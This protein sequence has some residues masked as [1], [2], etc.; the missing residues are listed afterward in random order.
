MISSKQ[1]EEEEM[2]P[3]GGGTHDFDLTLSSKLDRNG[4]FLFLVVAGGV[5]LGVEAVYLSIGELS[6]IEQKGVWSTPGLGTIFIDIAILLIEILFVLGIPALLS[7]PV[8][9]SLSE[10]GI[11]L[12]FS[13]GKRQLLS[14]ASPRT[15]FELYDMTG[16]PELI[17]L[18][19]AY[20]LSIPTLRGQWFFHRG[21]TITLEAF[22]GLLRAANDKNLRIRTLRGSTF[23]IGVSPTI[24][25]AQGGF[26]G[27]AL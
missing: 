22:N 2:M 10:E 3:A 21:G 16:Y 1:S 13:G 26:G 17:P 14:W 5:G 23:P 9:M 20:Y 15:R 27:A 7:G 8:R 12:E 24:H 11:R 4:P 19:R 18:D 25:R 6:V